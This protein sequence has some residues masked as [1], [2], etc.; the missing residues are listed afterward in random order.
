MYFSAYFST[1]FVAFFSAIFFAS[2]P[3]YAT[4]TPARPANKSPATIANAAP[5]STTPDQRRLE[6]EVNGVVQN[7][8]LGAELRVF[9]GD[10]VRLR[11]VFSD[12]PTTQKTR[13]LSYPVDL[14]GFQNQNPDYPA[15]DRNIGIN[16]NRDLSDSQALSTTSTERLFPLKI[17][18]AYSKEENCFLRVVNP[19]LEYAVARI[20]GVS[21]ILRPDQ[22]TTIRTTD[23]FKVETIHSNVSTPDDIAVELRKVSTSAKN[24]STHQ[25]IFSRSGYVFARVPFRVEQSS[26]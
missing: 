15:D 12:S 3:L 21:T 25:L 4:V 2:A 10:I 9:R 6:V 23:T 14:V 5:T 24:P 19:S 26:E 11:G 16:T 18:T 20:N 13:K 7:I 17:R 8:N 22:Q 1:Y